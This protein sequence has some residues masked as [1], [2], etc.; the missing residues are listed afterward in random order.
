MLA[1]D[2]VKRI[3]DLAQDNVENRFN[4]VLNLIEAERKRQPVTPRQVLTTDQLFELR[5]LKDWL[6]RQRNQEHDGALAR[7]TQRRHQRIRRQ[8]P[9]TTKGKTSNRKSKRS[10]GRKAKPDSLHGVLASTSYH[11][12]AKY[13]NHKRPVGTFEAGR[14]TPAEVARWIERELKHGPT[15]IVVT[16]VLANAALSQAATTQKDTN[17]K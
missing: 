9:T 11:L 3:P 8:Q 7:I 10:A 6:I 2:L 15:Q 16:R 1:A 13:G 12:L 14:R 5:C 4:V 17:A